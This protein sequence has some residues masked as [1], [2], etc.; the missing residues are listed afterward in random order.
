MVMGSPSQFLDGS[1]SR[2]ELWGARPVF[3]RA[4]HLIKD[5]DDPDEMGPPLGQEIMR[6]V[7]G[8]IEF[9]SQQLTAAAAHSLGQCRAAF[10]QHVRSTSVLSRG[11]GEQQKAMLVDQQGRTGNLRGLF[12]TFCC[13]FPYLSSINTRWSNKAQ[14]KV[15]QWSSI[16]PYGVLSRGLWRTYQAEPTSMARRESGYHQVS[17]PNPALTHSESA[18]ALK[19]LYCG[20]A[21]ANC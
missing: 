13:M 8:V 6:L 17:T 15:A 3:P 11:H 18:K 4:A 19:A 12:L 7:H 2:L 16:S 21:F 20:L 10:P 14:T 9:P 1:A 5:F